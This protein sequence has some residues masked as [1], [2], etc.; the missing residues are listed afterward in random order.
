MGNRSSQSWYHQHADLVA[1][2]D[3]MTAIYSGGFTGILPGGF[4]GG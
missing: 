3:E 4:D 1:L 2:A